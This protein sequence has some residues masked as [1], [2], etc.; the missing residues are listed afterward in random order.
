M[1]PILNIVIKNAR[2]CI[3]RGIFGHESSSCPKK[4]RGKYCFKMQQF[5]TPS[6]RLQ[7][8]KF[9][10]HLVLNVPLTVE[11]RVADLKINALV[12]RRATSQ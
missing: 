8:A 11:V 7:R 9:A 1:P 3:K 2:R 12:E 6:K 4:S 10:I 5:R